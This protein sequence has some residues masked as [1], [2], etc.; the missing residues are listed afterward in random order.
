M[1]DYQ[2]QN[3]EQRHTE[4]KNMVQNHFYKVQE[5][6]KQYYILCLDIYIDS[7]NV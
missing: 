3:E 7:K 1:D 2:L 6:A 5:N 4:E